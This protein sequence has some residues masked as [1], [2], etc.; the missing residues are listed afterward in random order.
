MNPQDILKK[1]MQSSKFTIGS[2]KAKRGEFTID[3][4]AQT[5]S[6]TVRNI[7][8]YQDRGL[9]APPQ[10]RGR[11]GF[12]N[13]HHV[14]RLQM[15]NKLL[16]RGYSLSNIKELVDAWENGQALDHVLGLDSAIAGDQGLES[17]IYVSMQDISNWFGETLTEDLML[18][19]L[20]IGLFELDIDRI[21]VP[22]PRT[23]QAGL[24]LFD[25]GIPFSALLRE[26][27]VLRDDVDRLTRSFV[28]LVAQ[29][30]VD[31]ISVNTLPSPTELEE[32]A[33]LIGRLRP[34][35]ESVV[36]VEMA[37]GLR[38]HANVYFGDKFRDIFK[39]QEQAK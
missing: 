9:L 11:T 24:A 38:R 29:H 4:L 19:A 14:T 31:P 7:R 37:K 23:L 8:A 12:Y 5:T 35:A 39:Q 10:R 32:L 1:L 34:L 26:I 21:K 16:E 2:A 25:A 15:I 18:Q 27:E 28:Q 13:E 36:N 3:E 30:L 33:G 20:R 6:I 17:P 22:S